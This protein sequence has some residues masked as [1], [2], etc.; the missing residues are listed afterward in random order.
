M[1]RLVGLT[2]RASA[3]RPAD[4]PPGLAVIT[5]QSNRALLSSNARCRREHKECKNNEGG[6]SGT[7]LAT[8][9]AVAGDVPRRRGFHGDPS[10]GRRNEWAAGVWTAPRHTPFTS[11]QLRPPPPHVRVTGPPRRYSLWHRPHRR[12][13]HRCNR[14][15]VSTQG[16]RQ[17]SFVTRALPV[18]CCR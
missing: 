18:D 14:G 2:G 6:G 9:S 13:D 7:G 3:M 12:R 11:M 1:I 16:A 10:P 5:P 8:R 15:N 17:A 4:L